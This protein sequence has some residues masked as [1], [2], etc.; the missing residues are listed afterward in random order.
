MAA[1][2]I[3]NDVTWASVRKFLP[4]DLDSFAV[5]SGALERRRGVAGGEALMRAILLNGLPNS[6][7]GMAADMAVELGIARMNKTAMFKRVCKAEPMLEGTFGHLL[8]FSIG[9]EERFGSYRLLAADATALCGPAAT[10]TN[11]RLHTVY[12]LGK[13]LP[14]S[15]DLT[16]ASGGETLV[17]HSSFGPGDLVLA[18]RGYG[19]NNS[20]LHALRCGAAILIRFETNSVKL[21]SEDG[22]RLT[23]ETAE[24]LADG[25]DTMDL[26]VRLPGWDGALRAIGTRRP[27]GR[28]VWLLTSL[29][30]DELPADQARTLYSRRWQVELFYKR[31]K[32]LLDFGALPSRD[33][34]T[35]RSWIWTK[36]ILAALAVLV[37]HERFS[38]WGAPPEPLGGDSARTPSARAPVVGTRVPRKTGKAE[39]AQPPPL[40]TRQ[41]THALEA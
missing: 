28:I 22:E 15:V 4:F 12:D 37:T 36:L 25:S 23:A 32:S 18:D 1:C 3:E 40:Q 30:R 16:D 5:E 11:F 38:P 35:A 26:A 24:Q 10:G 6:S 20:F 27:D 17:R 8:T 31:L 39:K 19:Y 14:L 41:A 21:Y 13:G 2:A 7:L 29:N 9:K 34:P 33:G